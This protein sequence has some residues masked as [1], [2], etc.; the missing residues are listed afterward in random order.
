MAGEF[1]ATPQILKKVSET[2]KAASQYELVGDA[3]SHDARTGKDGTSHMRVA[4]QAPSS[5]QQDRSVASE[6]REESERAGD[7]SSAQGTTWHVT[8]TI[9]W[10]E[11]P[12]SKLLLTRSR[13]EAGRKSGST[14]PQCYLP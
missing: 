14:A 6:R 7:E 8:N 11:L 13:R 5:V 9:A 12:G 3:T 10:T 1:A 4:F 2:Y